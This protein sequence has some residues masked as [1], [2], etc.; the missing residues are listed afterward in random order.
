MMKE[1]N[2]MTMEPTLEYRH[3][4]PYVAIRTQVTTQQLGTVLPPLFGEVFAWLGK[5]GVAPAGAPFWRYRIVDMNAQFD[6]EVGVPIA[7]A[8]SGN[9]RIT[10]GVLPSGRY[11]VFVHTGHPATLMDATARLLAWAKERRI[12]WQASEDQREWKARLEFY[13]TDPAVEPDMNKWQTELAFLT[14]DA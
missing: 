5:Q 11:A 4:Q 13:L 9:G 3:E 10:A 7:T 1:N 8:V 2:L 12:A 6:M 14:A